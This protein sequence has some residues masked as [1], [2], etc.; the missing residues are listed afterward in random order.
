MES[1]LTASD[2]YFSSSPCMDM[3][4]CGIPD[5]I[6]CENCDY[7]FESYKKV[8]KMMKEFYAM[9]SRRRSIW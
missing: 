6:A 1:T 8:S 7:E 9:L 4:C 5:R 2:L 3:S